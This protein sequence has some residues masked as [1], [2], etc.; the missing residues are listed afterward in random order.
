MFSLKNKT[1]LIISNEPW[2]DIWYSKHNWA[3]ELS[4]NN[5]V[6]FINPSSRWSG[7]IHFNPKIEVEKISETLSVISY[8]NVLPYTRF[9]LFRFFNEKRIVKK[10]LP[11]FKVANTSELVFWTFDP[12][13]FT[14]PTLFKA[15]KSI[16]FVTD[17]F[18]TKL[19]GALI[20][21][22]DYIISVS[23]SL[24]NEF[25]SK[26]VL[27]L[28]HGISSD[29]FNDTDDIDLD[30]FILYVGNIDH[31]INYVLLKKL[32]TNFPK[33]Q[34]LFIGKVNFNTNTLDI[35]NLFFQT[36]DW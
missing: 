17:K 18:Q 14:K 32:L 27:N 20:S 2:C 30:N 13:R 4:K 21:H 3:Y 22:V 8:T 23:S 26:K 1:I 34:F 16:Y 10:M 19:E 11:F 31:R 5:N 12:F 33:E 6:Y 15:S 28:T 36:F 24:T 35:A 29:E 25:K 7:G 9:S